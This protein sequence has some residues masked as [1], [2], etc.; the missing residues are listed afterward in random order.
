MTF[1]T[2]K[3]V[4]MHGQSGEVGGAEKKSGL[5]KPFSVKQEL[6]NRLKNKPILRQ[7]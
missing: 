7:R 1:A 5:V 6:V 4:C 3:I 2:L